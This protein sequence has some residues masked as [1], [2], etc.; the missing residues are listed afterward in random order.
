MRRFFAT[1]RFPVFTLALVAGFDA[2]VAVLMLVPPGD[3]PLARL[4][5]EFRRWCV[6]TS[7]G[8]TVALGAALT[9]LSQPLVYAAA[10]VLLWWRP[11]AEL[12]GRLR[13]AAPWAAAGLAGALVLGAGLGVLGR[14]ARAEAAA[15]PPPFPAEALRTAIPAPAF[16][17][18]DQDGRPVSL[19]ALRGRVVLLTAAYA[20]C[21]VSC[22]MILAEAKRAVAGAGGDVVVVAVT[23]DPARDDQA[24]RRRLADAQGVAAPGWR[25]AGGDPAAVEAALDAMGIERRRDPETGVIDH[26]NLFLLID[27]GG[28]VAY[29]F[30]LNQ[31]EWLVAALRVLLEE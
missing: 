2:L 25:I 14:P 6:P 3:G 7:D 5:A 12:R 17:L 8:G 20:S 16:E 30:G 23:L 27:R 15:G 24:A 10:L 9:F 13:A 29:R 26:A 4:A 28:A 1:Y 18:S 21:S 22:P 31:Q 19:A 11:L